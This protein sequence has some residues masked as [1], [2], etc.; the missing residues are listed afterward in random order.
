MDYNKLSLNELFKELNRMNNI[1]YDKCESDDVRTSAL[2]ENERIWEAI[3]GKIVYQPITITM[4]GKT[5][6]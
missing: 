1:Y 2:K 3:L 5:H 6:E 4:K